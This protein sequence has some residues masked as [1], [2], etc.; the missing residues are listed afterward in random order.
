MP[1]QLKP[2]EKWRFEVDVKTLEHY[3]RLA[4]VTILQLCASAHIGPGSYVALCRDGT[5]NM[6]VVARL[7]TY[8][9][10]QPGELVIWYPVP[11]DT[12]DQWPYRKRY[13]AEGDSN[14]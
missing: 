11:L 13:Q 3:R 10:V 4:G 5:C 6:H 9:K 1:W 8:Y 2:G 12:P 14:E 7:A